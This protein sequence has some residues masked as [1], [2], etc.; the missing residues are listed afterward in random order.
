MTGPTGK[1]KPTG[2]SKG[3]RER[4]KKDCPKYKEC[5]EDAALRNLACVPCKGCEENKK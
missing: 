3:N 4:E 5:L 1:S 2:V